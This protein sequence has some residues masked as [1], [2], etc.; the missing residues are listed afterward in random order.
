VEHQGAALPI[1]RIGGQTVFDRY[2]NTTEVLITYDATF[3][4]GQG[5]LFRGLSGA[6]EPAPRQVLL[7]HELV[8]AVAFCENFFGQERP[9]WDRSEAVALEAENDYR[10]QIF[11]P[12]RVGYDGSGPC[13]AGV[14]T[15][16]PAQPPPGTTGW[17]SVD[18]FV[19]TAA[20]GSPFAPDVQFLRDFRDGVL[21][22]TRAGDAFFREF[23]ERYTRMSP[24]IVAL[25]E[26]DPEARELVEWLAVRPLVAHLRR[27]IEFPDAPLD[28]VPEPWRAVLE[29][30]REELEGW[31]ER[32][33]LPEDFDVSPEEAVEELTIVMR[34]AL[35]T[36]ESRER[37]L[38]RLAR[39]GALPLPVGPAERHA[40]AER[41]ASTG[42]EPEEIE[43]I[44]G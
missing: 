42:R 8:H 18:C 14:M 11:A 19:A 6:Q 1:G 44:L 5:Y 25:M 31:C 24:P 7:F 16:P 13:V 43:R 30:L 22:R 41:L 37:Y 38:D 10:A 3:C 15:P 36:P 20:H 40:L 27:L 12:L 34:H 21:A 32:V 29:E 9:T 2:P 28:G 33:P 4:N 26:R 39:R 17:P 35:R 23:Y